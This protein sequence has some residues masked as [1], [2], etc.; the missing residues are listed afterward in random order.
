MDVPAPAADEAPP[1]PGELSLEQLRGELDR[2]D[3]GLHELLIERS[4][5]VMRL[6]RARLKSGVA[7]RPGREAA[8]IRRRL[9]HHRGPLPRSTIVRIWR[10]LLAGTTAMQ[11]PCS[12]AVAETDPAL[13]YA[14]LAREQFGALTPM[15]VH[16]SARQAIAELSAGRAAIA[17]VPAPAES[18]PGTAWW[19]T[20]SPKDAP[21]IRVVARLPFWLP[22]PEGLPRL[23]ALVLSS[24]PPDPSG[25]DR[26][27]LS[28]VFAPELSRARLVGAITAAGFLPGL[29]LIEREPR[30]ATAQAL[31]DVA[32]FVEDADPRLAHLRD[33]A[34]P[35]AV[36]GA[37]AVPETGVSA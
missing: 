20:L 18:E 37:Y 1:E 12:V 5:V 29:V 26:S 22:R 8:I 19:R 35:A 31:A 17:V 9:A 15:R 34:E 21:R 6:C 16:R 24:A 33:L 27:L 23:A 3:E 13:G 25:D 28:L 11:G 10:E 14:A 36:L 32:G 30:A 7:L 4:E 2:L